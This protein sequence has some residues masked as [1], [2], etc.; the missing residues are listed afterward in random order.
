MLAALLALTLIAAACGDDDDTATDGTAS[1]SSE[2]ATAQ[3]DDG[4]A[5]ADDA[6]GAADAGEAETVRIVSILDENEAQGQFFPDARAG[7]EA[8]EYFINNNG[9]LGGSGVMVELDVCVGEI[10]PNVN[11]ECAREAVDSGAVAVVGSAICTNDTAYPILTENN[12]ANIGPVTCLPSTFST[13]N[14]FPTNAGIQGLAT[15]EASIG[16]TILEGEV[17]YLSLVAN[18]S[19][20]AT[21]PGFDAALEAAGCDPS[22]KTVEVTQGTLDGAQVVAQYVGADVVLHLLSP[23]QS[24][25]IIN[26]AAQQGTEAQLVFGPTNFSSRALANTGDAAEGI[27]TARWYAAPDNPGASEGYDIYREALDATGGLEYLADEFGTTAFV[28]VWALDQAFRDCADC[29]LTRE[30]ALEAMNNLS[31]FNAG[32]MAPNIDFSTPPTHSLAEMFPRL[33]VWG[34]FTGIVEGGEIVTFGDGQVV[35]LG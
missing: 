13:E 30:G 1:E 34:G 32:G 16:C 20:L 18:D 26:A 33:H 23:P 19:I 9:G 10:D 6:D 35:E 27:I 31:G 3:A 25:N 4:D 5:A 15:L 7:L 12:V 17:F 11:A 24:P 21:A 29:E 14:S 28:G 8:A 2:S 22:A